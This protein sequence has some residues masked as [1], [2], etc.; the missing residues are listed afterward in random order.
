M[1]GLSSIWS[2]RPSIWERLAPKRRYDFQ[3][4]AATPSNLASFDVS[5][6]VY[7]RL[8]GESIVGAPIQSNPKLCYRIEPLQPATSI[9]A[10][11][12]EPLQDWR[13]P[14]LRTLNSKNA[15]IYISAEQS[16]SARSLRVCY[17]WGISYYLLHVWPD[18]GTGFV[19]YFQP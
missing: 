1:S 18:P 14:I 15:S 2:G 16:K 4:Y 10:V 12:W 7:G 17:I 11:P 3:R 13:E 6:D 8:E 19:L 9:N 5:L